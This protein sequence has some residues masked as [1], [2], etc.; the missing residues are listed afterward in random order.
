[1]YYCFIVWPHKSREYNLLQQVKQTPCKSVICWYCARVS[2]CVCSSSAT[3]PITFRCLEENNHV[4]KRV[5]RFVLPVGATINMDGTALYEAVAAIFIAQVNDMDLNFGQ[6]LTIRYIW[7]WMFMQWW[8]AVYTCSVT[9]RLEALMCRSKDHTHCVL[10]EHKK[11][12]SDLRLKCL[13]NIW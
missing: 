5:T 10:C 12:V 1:M 4:D 6:I 13:L 3:L 9:K 7:F 2:L 8:Y 11:C